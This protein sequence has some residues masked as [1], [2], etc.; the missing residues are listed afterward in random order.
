MITKNL[1]LYAK[2]STTAPLVEEETPAFASAIDQGADFS[3]TVVSSEFMTADEVKGA[4]T[5]KNIS[6]PDQKD[7]IEMT[8]DGITFEIRGKGG[9][10]EGATYKLT[11]EDERLYFQD[12]GPSVR[13][14]NFT[15]AKE[16][17]MNLSLSK[18]MI[19]IPASEI[20][21][22]TENGKSV[23]SLSTPLVRM[24][25][26]TSMNLSGLVEGTFTY[27]G[28][29]EVGDTVCIY[30]GIRPDER[31][32]DDT[33]PGADGE[34]AYLAITAVNGNTYSYKCADINDVLF[35]PDVLPVPNAADTDGDPYNNSLTVDES[36]MEFSDDMYTPM[37][38]DS[39]T[40]VDEGDFLA[41]YDG[42]FGVNARVT[43]YGRIT[44]VRSEN[45]MMIITYTNVTLDEMM[46]AM[47]IYNTDQI[48]G[49]D[50]LEGVDLEAL[51]ASI[52]QQALDSGSA[53]E[54]AVPGRPCAE[55][56][57]LYQVERRP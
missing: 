44:S 45:G 14:Y 26:D 10:E 20:S 15:I 18:D 6:S 39:Q 23:K 1:T 34:I 22:L 31:V 17:V 21:N 40:T 41:F 27:N 48:K 30:K 25:G 7:F 47:D 37:G 11:L 36:V 57:V 33:R 51:A 38:L 32:L 2:Y 35:K 19:Y 42:E 3:I 53:E 4:I 28:N 5:A 49:E 50:I 24:S 29:L 13:N 55:N 16:D 46:S 54:A 43:G 9:F 52:E 8:G 56:R 12:F